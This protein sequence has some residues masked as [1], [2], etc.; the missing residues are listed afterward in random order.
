MKILV[1]IVNSR[2]IIYR[3]NKHKVNSKVNHKGKKR[4]KFNIKKKI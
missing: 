2:K 1:G 3:N 4:H